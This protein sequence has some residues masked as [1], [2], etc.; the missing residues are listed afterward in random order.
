VSPADPVRARLSRLLVECQVEQA[1]LDRLA[2]ELARYRADLG[3]ADPGRP[4]Q[5]LVAV[6]LHDYFTAAE[7]FFERIARAVDGEVPAGPDSHRELID[8]MAADLPPLRPPVITARQR[9][10]LHGLR[11]FR[12]FFRHAY[13][14]GLDPARLRGHAD[15]LLAAHAGLAAGLREFLD[16]VRRTRDALPVSG[17]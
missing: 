1:A 4:V 15:D 10:W 3:A 8:Q 11:V 2:A 5:A 7:A 16:F 14:I 9:T 6:D 13:A 12:H 17:A